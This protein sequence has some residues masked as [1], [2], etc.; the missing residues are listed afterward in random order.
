MEEQEK[1][2][3]VVSKK[4]SKEIPWRGLSHFAP[5]G[6]FVLVYLLFW[7]TFIDLNPWWEALFAAFGSYYYLRHRS[8]I[9]MQK[10]E[11]PDLLVYQLPKAAILQILKDTIP[12]FHVGDRWWIL[13]WK[14]E[15]KGEMKFRVNYEI[16]IPN[17]PPHKQQVVLDVYISPIEDNQRTAVRLIYDGETAPISYKTV[18]EQIT[19]TTEA[20]D[21]QLKRAEQGKL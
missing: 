19:A 4:Q 5:T 11:Q 3:P 2:K 20:I 10:I 12:N 17:K 16:G 15:E 21:Y 18:L 1:S 7:L 14:N 8:Q 6:V 13:H 9:A